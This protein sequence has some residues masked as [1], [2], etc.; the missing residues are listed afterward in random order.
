[1]SYTNFNTQSQAFIEN[2]TAELFRYRYLAAGLVG[3]DLRA[4]FRRSHLG[5]LWAVLQPL[6]FSLI[7]AIVWS[8]VFKAD[9][10]MAF[11][12]YVFSGMLIWEY[13]S[14]CVIIGLDS[15]TSSA[16][17]LKQARI[18]FLIFQL[19]VPLSGSV[20]LGCGMIGLLGLMITVGEFP[21]IGPH[22]LLMPI[23]AVML[24]FFVVP[25]SI[26]ASIVGPS[27]RDARY[28][29]G[30]ALQAVFFLSPVMLD[31][32]VLHSESLQLLQYLNPVIP[33]L[34]LFRGPLLHGALWSIQDV[35]IWAAWTSGLWIIA[36]VTMFRAG[37]KIIFAL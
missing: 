20:V 35:A 4:R 28:V 37:R 14:Q 13:L 22:L 12:V 26:I 23:F 33:I 11:T 17:Y 24:F 36:L 2:Y 18:P 30:L 15:L 34:D 1:M 3:S 27:F 16:G 5:I 32:A 29:I 31:R 9:S 25:I 7:I 21:P 8:Q 6:G 19:R 10:F